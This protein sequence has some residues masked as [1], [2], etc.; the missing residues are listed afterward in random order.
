MAKNRYRRRKTYAE[1]LA[2]T[3]AEQERKWA[4]AERKFRAL[5][6]AAT[7]KVQGCHS[8]GMYDKENDRFYYFWVQL[9]GGRRVLVE[10][11]LHRRSVHRVLAGAEGLAGWD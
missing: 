11:L 4:E 1:S 3:V 10:K 9:R 7:E 5:V 2:E 8:M 6:E